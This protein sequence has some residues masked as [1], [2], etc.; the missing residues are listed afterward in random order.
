MTI[1]RAD[2]IVGD[3]IAHGSMRGPVRLFLIAAAMVAGA[4]AFAPQPASAVSLLNGSALSANGLNIVVS[5]CQLTLAGVAQS[6]CSAGNL[7]IIADAGP[8]ASI[9]IQGAGG[10]NIFSAALGSGLYDVNFKLDITAINPGTTITSAALAMFGSTT[11]TPSFPYNLLPTGSY[12]SVG[13]TVVPFGGP[14]QNMS[15]NLGAATSSSVSFAAVTSLS[16]T[17]DLKLNA[18]VPG[19]GTLTLSHVTQ[20]YLP[21]PE[22]ATIG[23][24]L[25]GAGGIIAARQ[26]RRRRS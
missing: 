23:L 22:P 6:D 16:V 24:L 3:T 14:S 17:K 10:G 8:G 4:S 13:E 11:G 21:A 5:N 20:S 15:V 9:R 26:R 2:D 19:V 1:G 25:V 12:V 7:E 18:A